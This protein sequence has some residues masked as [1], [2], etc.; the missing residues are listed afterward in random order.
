VA[1][2]PIR[3]GLLELDVF[4]FKSS[5]HAVPAVYRVAGRGGQ[6]RETIRFL[7]KSRAR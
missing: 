1:L 2:R 3:F 7:R 5:R 6:I 4:A